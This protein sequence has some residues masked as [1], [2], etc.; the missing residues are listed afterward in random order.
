MQNSLKGMLVQSCR[1]RL[2]CCAQVKG[3]GGAMSTQANL[4]R[5]LPDDRPGD[6]MLPVVKLGGGLVAPGTM[7]VA[8][9]VGTAA[10]GGVTGPAG[11][12]GE[13][14]AAGG[15]VPVGVELVGVAVGVEA[16]GDVG[17]AGEVPVGVGLA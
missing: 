4:P 14:V 5:G 6:A 1:C 11:V 13:G 10:V 12:L 9:D 8:G 3:P 15:V 17:A 7:P 16:L 2:T